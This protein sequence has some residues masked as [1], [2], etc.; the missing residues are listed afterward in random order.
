MLASNRYLYSF[1]MV[2][3][4]DNSGKSE[5]SSPKDWILHWPSH[6]IDLGTGKN[7]P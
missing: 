3:S 5:F 7:S 6:E 4:R 1:T 2:E